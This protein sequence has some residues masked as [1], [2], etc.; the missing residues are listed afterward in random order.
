MQVFVTGGSGFLGQH[1]LDA[2][3][4]AGHATRALARSDRAADTVAAHGAD[5]VAG[6]LSDHR[7]LE[8][9]MQ[10]CH[11]VVHAAAKTSAWGEPRSFHDVN[12]DGTKAVIATAR[13]TEVTRLVH[14]STEAV[15]ADGRPLVD[16]DETYPRPERPVGWYARTKA[17]AEDAVLDANSSEL[18]TVVVRPRLVWGPGDTTVLPAV[19]EAARAGRWAWI[20][21]GDYLTSTCHVVN[22][23]EGILRAAED[24]RGGEVYFLTDGEPMQT[25]AFLTALAATAGVELGDRSIPRWLAELA[26][27]GCEWVWRALPLK[28]EPPLTRTFV[29]LGGQEMTVDDRKARRELGYQG[30]VSREEGLTRLAESFDR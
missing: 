3:A 26:A 19:V 10:G 18:T 20:D 17:I 24:G 23:A 30:T 21:K 8:G 6:D 11:A 4:D 16:V 12:V 7:A 27:R 28:E 15:L 5:P 13:D 25:R 14:V 29:A 22:A 9:G 1:L 2:M